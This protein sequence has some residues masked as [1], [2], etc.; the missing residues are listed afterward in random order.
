MIDHVRSVLYEVSLDSVCFS[1]L[2]LY[3]VLRRL[4]GG[5]V[6]AGA[7]NGHIVATP[8]KNKKEPNGRYVIA[9]V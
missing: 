4:N 3:Q 7:S 1:Q 2:Q 9:V 5:C 8:H 6:L